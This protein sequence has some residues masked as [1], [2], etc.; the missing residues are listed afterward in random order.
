MDV[1]H[2]KCVLQLN[3]NYMRLGWATP[4][5]AFC[6]LMGESKGGE[7]PAMA[8]NIYYEL[9]EFGMPITDK[10]ISFDRLDWEGWSVLEPRQGGLDKLIRTSKRVFRIPSIIISSH[11]R[12]MPMKE[13]RPTPQALRK[14]DNNRCC[15][16]GVELTNKTYSRDH[17]TPVCR[18]GKDTWLNLV[19]CHKEI[20]SKKGDKTYQE[21]G[22]KLLRKPTAPKA[23]P[24]CRLIEGNLH[25]DHYFFP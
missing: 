2:Q 24:L 9:D 23:I 21:V 1:L 18:G 20:N 10:M 7:S 13:Q 5:Q 15:Y 17:L 11:F 25:P 8:L 22:L 14:R 6:A 3:A 4:V 16:S 12:L 19:S